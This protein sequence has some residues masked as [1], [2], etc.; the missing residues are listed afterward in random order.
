MTMTMTWGFSMTRKRDAP[1]LRVTCDHVITCTWGS[2]TR[3]GG[4]WWSAASAAL[5]TA[6]SPRAAPSPPARLESLSPPYPEGSCL[7]GVQ[8]GP[9]INL[10]HIFGQEGEHLKHHLPTVDWLSGGPRSFREKF[11]NGTGP[12]QEPEGAVLP[13]VRG[14]DGDGSPAAG[15]GEAA[16]ADALALPPP[17]PCPRHHRSGTLVPASVTTLH[18]LH[19][20]HH[21]AGPGLLQPATGGVG[22]GQA[23][24]RG[25]G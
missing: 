18:I 16:A 9:Q 13:V 20:W 25:C 6:R 5:C 4:A 7:G 11:N 17:H 8:L 15:R 2:R 21:S 3:A 24:G 22:G 1:G 10:V 12:H 14:Q 23:Q 19:W